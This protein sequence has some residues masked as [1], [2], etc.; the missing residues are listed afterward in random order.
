MIGGGQLGRMFALAAQ[1]MD[2]KVAVLD[3]D[4]ES[5]AAQVSNSSFEFANHKEFSRIC[6]VATYEFELV[7]LD[8]VMQIEKETDL[9]PGSHILNIKKSRRSEKTY[10]SANGFPVAGYHLANDKQEL[11]DLANKIPMPYVIKTAFG[12]YDGKG[13]MYIKTGGD[14]AKLEQVDLPAQ[15]F[16][17]EEFIEYTK[18]IS[19]ICARNAAG[20]TA[21]FPIAENR[22]IDGILRESIAP[23][24]I[25]EATSEAV[26]RLAIDLAENLG[27]VGLLAIEL[28]IKGD[29]TILINEI[30]PRPH[31]SGHFTM[32]ACETSQF[33]QLLR[34]ICNLP[35]GGTRLLAPAAMLNIVGRGKEDYD[36]NK[37][38][39]TVGSH[40]HLYGK[41][42]VRPGRKMGHINIT[43]SS[44]E[45]VKQKL[46]S[47][48]SIV[49]AG[50]KGTL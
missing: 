21:L 24:D 3:D 47:V 49:Y 28:F 34:A 17:V 16:V 2:Y 19:I 37:I 40:I 12:G 18:E 15:Q 7:N 46:K 39:E 38:F 6:Q 14:L 41:S 30:A 22:H 20:D 1:E 36:I 29:G 32:E 48:E 25:D 35:L 27:L 50:Q 10:L 42:E 9:K 26:K 5:P 33:H 31:N 44:P 13:Q 4:P 43:G 8:I 11:I 45:E 23:A